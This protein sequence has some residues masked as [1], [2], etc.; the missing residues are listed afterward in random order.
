MI[1]M[2]VVNKWNRRLLR[3]VSRRGNYGKE[4]DDITAEGDDRSI[5][6]NEDDVRISDSSGTVTRSASLRTRENIMQ[7]LPPPGQLSQN[8]RQH[9][10]LLYALAYPKRITD[11]DMAT[12]RASSKRAPVKISE[13]EAE[14]KNEQ[15]DAPAS[16]ARTPITEA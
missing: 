8:S 14:T 12:A 15:Q 4:V 9:L 2:K 10:D 5:G 13:V 1:S 3:A 11:K 7:S 6:S 16:I